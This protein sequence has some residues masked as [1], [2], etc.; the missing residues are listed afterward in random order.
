MAKCQE[1]G[2]DPEVWQRGFDAGA[3]AASDE[4]AWLIEFFGHGS[5]TY[6]GKTEEGLGMTGDHSVA[7]R[8]AR[9][10]DADMVIDDFGWTRPNV[11]AI[12]HMWC[13][14][15]LHSLGAKTALR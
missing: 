4:T 14:P 13:G 7:V 11:Q 9:K 5:P 1:D 2:F 3:K 6:Y 12:E 15:T 10:E 8:F